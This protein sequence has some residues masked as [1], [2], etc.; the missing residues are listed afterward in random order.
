MLDS[1]DLL[2]KLA[3]QKAVEC[4]VK[5]YI[6]PDTQTERELEGLGIALSQY[7]KWDGVVLMKIL[8][9]ALTDANFHSEAVVVNNMIAQCMN[10]AYDLDDLMEDET[11]MY[12]D[13]DLKTISEKVQDEPPM[14]FYSDPFED[15]DDDL[16]DERGNSFYEDP[17][18]GYDGILPVY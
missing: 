12:G 11:Y 17:F 18:E 4:F 6:T 8:Q 9:Y 3:K 2:D 1:N 10:E 5:E 16:I 15:L 7:V 13:G 14:S